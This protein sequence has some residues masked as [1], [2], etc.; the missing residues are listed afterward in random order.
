MWPHVSSGFVSLFGFWARMSAAFVSHV[1]SSLVRCVDKKFMEMK[2]S[3]V[4]NNTRCLLSKGNLW[5]S[6]VTCFWGEQRAQNGQT[7]LT[8]W[9]KAA[10]LQSG[11]KICQS[12]KRAD[13]RRIKPNMKTKAVS[14]PWGLCVRADNMMQVERTWSA[15]EG[16]IINHPA[17][18]LRNSEDT[19][20]C[21]S[22]RH[23][24]QHEMRRWGECKELVWSDW[25]NFAKMDKSPTQKV[26]RGDASRIG[27]ILLTMFTS[28]FICM[29]IM[30]ICELLLEWST[31]WHL[32]AAFSWVTSTLTILFEPKQN[33][34]YMRDY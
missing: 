24:Y 11:W 29:L 25:W 4:T 6:D 23:G 13:A 16:N 19:G 34:N 9:P 2:M 12:H 15:F 8:D 28:R 32:V 3:V 17:P 18:S 1:V 7:W 31:D 5:K 33:N 20:P 26:H 27:E 10:W 22:C 14:S 30:F 21:L